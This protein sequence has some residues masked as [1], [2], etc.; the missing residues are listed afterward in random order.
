VITR[1]TKFIAL[2]LLALWLPVTQHC[3]LQ[4]AGVLA[5]PSDCH[6]AADCPPEHQQKS[7]ESDNCQ[8]VESSAL[9][10]S[11]TKLKLTA[12]T[13]LVCLCCL[14]D[15]TP[16]TISVRLISPAQTDVPPELA[17]TWQFT[18]RAAPAPR[19]PGYLA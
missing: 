7:C 10:N 13:A 17:P 8:T 12:P 16:A 4:A 14:H 19:A 18:T 6:E 9:Q 15:I 5:S 2:L 11:F 1:S 3:D